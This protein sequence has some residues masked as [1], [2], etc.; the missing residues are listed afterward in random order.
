MMSGTESNSISSSSSS[1]GGADDA[2]G[3]SAL[4]T[5]L[6]RCFDLVQCVRFYR[7]VVVM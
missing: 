6:D 4:G 5:D 1:R 2:T 3:S 7:S